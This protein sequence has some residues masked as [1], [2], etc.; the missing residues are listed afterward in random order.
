MPTDA[1][2]ALGA[3]GD[4]FQGI[5]GFVGG[6]ASAKAYKKAA[7]YAEQNA[8]IAREAGDI[9]LAQTGRQIF[10]VLGQQQAGYAGAGLTAGGSAQA[11]IRDSVSQG[12]LEKAII[13]AQALIDV[14]AYKSQAEQFKG[15][16]KAAKAGGWGDL[17]GGIMSA[18]ASVAMMSDRRLK[19]DVV[20][21]GMHGELGLY[22]FRFRGDDRMQVG[23]MADEVAIHAPY[24]LGPVVDGYQTVDYYKIGL[25]HLMEGV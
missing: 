19:T 11:V 18:A 1:S 2:L 8:I 7:K 24:A 5:G 25:G 17:A 22:R 3:A 16:A 15:M 6:Q 10:K 4:L 21:I 9:K 23:V 13:N 12:A 14:N 20:K